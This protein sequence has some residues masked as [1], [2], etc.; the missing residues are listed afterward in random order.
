MAAEAFTKQYAY[1]FRH[2]YGKEGARKNY[3][4]NSCAKIIMGTPPE[5]GAY[6]GCPFRHMPDTQLTALLGSV[7]IS[8]SEASEMVKIAKSGN[9][10]LSCQKHFELTHPG[11]SNLDGVKGDAVS[12]HPNQWFKASVQYSKLKASTTT[13]HTSSA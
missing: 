7:H 12:N 5:P 1:S 9:P 4:P 2:M 10:Q 11:Y 8:G 6:H 13:P 3:T